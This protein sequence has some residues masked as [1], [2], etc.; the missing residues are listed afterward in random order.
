[1]CGI[2]GYFGKPKD[3]E[4]VTKLLKAL[5]VNSQTLGRHG[6]GYVMYTKDDVYSKKGAMPA[7]ALFGMSNYMD[8]EII[9]NVDVFIGH[10]RHA[11]MG[12]RTN[13]NTHPFF[14][15]EI[16][17]VHN[18]T[19][20]EI[21]QELENL[22]LEE[23]MEGETDSEALLHCLEAV[24]VDGVGSVFEKLMDYSTVFYNEIERKLFFARDEN[25]PM[26]IYDLR[27]QLGIRIFCSKEKIVEKALRKIGL[28]CNDKFDTMP[29]HLYMVEAGADTIDRQYRYRDWSAKNIARKARKI[30]KKKG[31]K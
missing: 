26:V 25:K 2:F 10:T 20:T 22:E 31:G 15:E 1:M 3:A 6:S 17:L 14:G 27:R 13:E 19:T 8:A 23:K 29:Y 11:S 28:T 18:G 12:R 30:K 21:F 4:K 24:G 7:H 9:K 16:A 5:A